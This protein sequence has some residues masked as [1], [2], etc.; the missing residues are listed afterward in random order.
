MNNTVSNFSVS[1]KKE[2]IKPEIKGFEL[3]ETN[4]GPTTRFS[5]NTYYHT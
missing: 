4:G 1:P 3:N 5:E 2:W